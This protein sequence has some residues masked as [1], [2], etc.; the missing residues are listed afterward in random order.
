MQ[1]QVEEVAAHPASS[2]RWR[3]QSY[4]PDPGR[5]H[6]RGPRQ[7]GGVF[8]WVVAPSVKLVTHPKASTDSCWK[9]I[10]VNIHQVSSDSENSSPDK[11][12][13]WR[14]PGESQ[15]LKRRTDDL[16]SSLPRPYKQFKELPHSPQPSCSAWHSPEYFLPKRSVA[17][18]QY[19]AP[20]PP[21]VKKSTSSLS[22][23]PTSSPEHQAPV[24]VSKHLLPA[25]KCLMP[26]FE[27]PPP[28]LKRSAPVDKPSA[29][30]APGAP[31]ASFKFFCTH[32]RRPFLGAHQAAVGWHFG[33]APESSC[34]DQ[35]L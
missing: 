27:H 29:S 4:S 10:S 13:Q 24:P 22:K 7:A 32:G 21:S 18:H 34:Y 9:G 30:P 23:R 12:R 26:A 16:V 1:V 15:P 28:A 33:F 3:S 25:P 6:T 35:A 8:P 20:K 31:S 2:P 14:F 11:R 5:R 17:E 19:L